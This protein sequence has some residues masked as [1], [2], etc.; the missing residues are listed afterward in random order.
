MDKSQEEGMK[1]DLYRDAIKSNGTGQFGT[2]WILHA[3]VVGLDAALL[4]RGGVVSCPVTGLSAIII[5][6]SLLYTLRVL[7]TEE[8]KLNGYYLRDEEYEPKALSQL[9]ALLAGILTAAA[10]LAYSFGY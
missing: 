8:K 7:T 10:L 1:L 6:G 3:V 4:L 9:P 5:M 2:F